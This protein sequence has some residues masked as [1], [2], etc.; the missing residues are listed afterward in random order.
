MIFFLSLGRDLHL[1]IYSHLVEGPGIL[2]AQVTYL[3]QEGAQMLQQEGFHWELAG[4][5][6]MLT[7]EVERPYNLSLDLFS[8][9]KEE[10]PIVWA[11]NCTGEG[12]DS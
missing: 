11:F 2:S 3:K 9:K 6:G 8:T 7:K 12:N 5:L 10:D 4:S 1:S